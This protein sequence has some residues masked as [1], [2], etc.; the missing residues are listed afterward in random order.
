MQ[1][2]LAAQLSSYDPLSEGL[3]N[4]RGRLMLRIPPSPSSPPHHPCKTRS[5]WLVVLPFSMASLGVATMADAVTFLIV[6]YGIGRRYNYWVFR[7]GV[8]TVWHNCSHQFV[9]F[10]LYFFNI[11]HIKIPTGRQKRLEKIWR[12]T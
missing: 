12:K 10:L 7:S 11:W 4:C 3:S 2:T 1:H 9:I 5:G 6:C 8:W